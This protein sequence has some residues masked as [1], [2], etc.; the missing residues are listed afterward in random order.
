[1]VSGD[2]TS[3]WKHFE[4]FKDAYKAAPNDLFDFLPSEPLL[5]KYKEDYFDYDKYIPE[6]VTALNI[7]GNFDYK[8]ILMARIILN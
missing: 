3:E 1:M 5:I 8:D 2:I 7:N 4:P 6:Y